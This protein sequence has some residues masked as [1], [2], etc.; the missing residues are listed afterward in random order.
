MLAADAS[1]AASSSSAASSPLKTESSKAHAAAAAVEKPETTE[2]PAATNGT[3]AASP[4]AASTAAHADAVHDKAHAGVHA[5]GDKRETES[6][7]PAAAEGLKLPADANTP[8]TKNVLEQC[9]A[10][11]TAMVPS[12]AMRYCV[13]MIFGRKQRVEHPACLID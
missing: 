7:D 2:H 13:V 11:M 1:K 10:E 6:G 9:L 5:P 8:G 4:S 3:A 12:L